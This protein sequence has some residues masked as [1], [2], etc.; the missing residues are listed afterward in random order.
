M[1]KKGIP[2]WVRHID[3][4]GLT[5]LFMRPANGRDFGSGSG[6]AQRLRRSNLQRNPKRHRRFTT[7]GG[8]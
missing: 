3:N 5:V 4:P 1:N 7:G 2:G 6:T 8:N